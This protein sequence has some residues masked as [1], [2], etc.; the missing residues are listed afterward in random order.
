MIECWLGP[1]PPWRPLYEA[2][3]RANPNLEFLVFTDQVSRI[4]QTGNIRYE[5]TDADDIARRLNC[6]SGVCIEMGEGWALT[7]LKPAYGMLFES[8]LRDHDFW[9]FHDSDIIWGDTA[10][11]LHEEIL[12][13]HDVITASAAWLVGHFTLFK[14]GTVVAQPH[15]HIPDYWN[16]I[17]QSDHRGVCV[18]EEI[19]DH[20]LARLERDGRIKILRS[21]WMLCDHM[22][23]RWKRRAVERLTREDRLDGSQVFAEG[24]CI[25]NGRGLVHEASGREALYFH[26]QHWKTRYRKQPGA[27]SPHVA[28]YRFTPERIQ[29]ARLVRHTP[30]ACFYWLRSEFFHRMVYKLKCA[31]AALRRAARIYF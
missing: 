31:K 30:A 17:Q 23:P 6:C 26:F 8:Y 25:W 27:C 13:G 7:K 1:F 20:A 18:D 11:F 22:H 4:E 19:L 21:Q 28:E 3:C 5:P 14:N 29:A 16:L 10:R 15:R 9:G 12:A 2:S 24:I